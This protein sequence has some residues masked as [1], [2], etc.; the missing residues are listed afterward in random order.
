MSVSILKSLDQNDIV[1]RSLRCRNLY[2]ENLSTSG[3]GPLFPNKYNYI[4]SGNTL[5][6][7]QINIFNFIPPNIQNNQTIL[8]KVNTTFYNNVTNVSSYIK[9][10]R[11]FRFNPLTPLITLDYTPMEL[12]SRPNGSS[13]YSQVLADPSNLS[14]NLS[15]LPNS[16]ES[17]D[18]VVDVSFLLRT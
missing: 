11:V 13:Y 9:Q 17:T 14:L 18:Y 1:C 5:E 3:I 2:Y 8:C 15:I 10:T 12:I 6:N 16:S 4:F 7:Q